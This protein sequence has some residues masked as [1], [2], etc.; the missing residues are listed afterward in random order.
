[1]FWVSTTTEFETL[2]NVEEESADGLAGKGVKSPK[3]EPG[4]VPE[5]R[6]NPSRTIQCT[7]IHESSAE[8]P[9]V[10]RVELVPLG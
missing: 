10:G 1:M 3:N 8:R 5:I 7:A 2:D 6:G 9:V 4:D